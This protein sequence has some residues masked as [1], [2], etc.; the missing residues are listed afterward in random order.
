MQWEQTISPSDYDVQ[1]KGILYDNWRQPAQWLGW[2]ETPKHFPKPNLHQKKAMVTVWRSTACLIHYSFLNPSK[3]ITSENYAQQID[4]MHWKLQCLQPTWVKRMG[5]ILLMT[6]PSC[7]SHN[8]HFK[9][10]MNWATTFASS[11]VF[12][13][14]LTNQLL[15]LQHLDTFL[16]RK[17]LPQPAAC[18]KCFPSV[19]QILRYGFLC[20]RINLFFIGKNVVIVMVPILFNKDV[21]ERSYNDLK[22]MVWN[23]GYFITNLN[24]ISC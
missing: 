21:F 19:H 11:G 20:Y 1:W 14:P 15:V 6:T 12:T 5:P 4:Q 16:Q 2:E 22:F 7:M 23:H 9:S 8:Q 18:R 17:T 10:W 24:S 13:W 3:T